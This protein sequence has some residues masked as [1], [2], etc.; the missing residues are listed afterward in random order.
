[1]KLHK[2]LAPLVIAGVATLGVGGVAAASTS[3][4]SEASVSSQ[5]TTRHCIAELARLNS[6]KSELD[7]KIDVL[8]RERNA[9]LSH[10]D[11]KLAARLEKD[12]LRLQARKARVDVKIRVVKARC[13]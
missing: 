8:Q 12:I 11:D 5:P 4:T 1:M 10:H 6:Q 2:L 13:T 3:T 9:A 7:G